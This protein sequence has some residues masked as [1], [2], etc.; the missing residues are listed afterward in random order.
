MTTAMF[1]KHTLLYCII[2]YFVYRQIICSKISS[3]GNR[4]MRA[5]NAKIFFLPKYF[6]IK[7][8][9]INPLWVTWLLSTSPLIAY[10]YPNPYPTTPHLS[11]VCSLF[12]P[13][14]CLHILWMNVCEY[15]LR[16]SVCSE[17]LFQTFNSVLL[18]HHQCL[19]GR[20][21]KT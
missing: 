13:S 6:F 18:N 19:A 12:I 11:V 4:L 5:V 20:G 8:T 14:F 10:Q 16:V 9:Q 7:S 3:F 21:L 15:L 2:Y 17:I 1:I